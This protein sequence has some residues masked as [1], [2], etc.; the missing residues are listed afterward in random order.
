[1][2]FYSAAFLVAT[3]GFAAHAYT[4]PTVTPVAPHSFQHQHGTPTSSST[5]AGGHVSDFQTS[6]LDKDPDNARQTME[7]FIS[8]FMPAAAAGEFEITSTY[9]TAHNGI[10]HV[11]T[12]QVIDGVPVMNGVG[13]LNLDRDGNVISS[14]DSFWTGTVPAHG[15]P[16]LDKA[17]AARKFIKA[18]SEDGDVA[19]VT[20]HPAG[21]ARQMWV[22]NGNQLQLAWVFEVEV[23]NLEHVVEVAI[24]ATNGDVLSAHDLVIGDEEDFADSSD[25]EGPQRKLAQAGSAAKYRGWGVPN[26][27]PEFGDSKLHE[28]PQNKVPEASPLGWHQTDAAQPAYRDTRGNNVFA[29]ENSADSSSIPP[30]GYRPESQSASALEFDFPMD[31]TRD[32]AA[33]ENLDATVTNL[34]LM[35]NIMHDLLYTYGFDEE[36]GNFQSNNFG[37]GGRGNDPLVANALDGSGKNNANMYTP[38]D[39]SSPV[40]RMYRW[41]DLPGE[42]RPSSLDGLVVAHE[43]VHGLSNRLTGGPTNSGCLYTLESGGMGEGWSDYVGVMMSIGE[44]SGFDGSVGVGSWLVGGR[45]I[46]RYEYS[47]DFSVNPFTFSDVNDASGVHEIGTIWATMLWDM[48]ADLVTQVG[49]SDDIYQSSDGASAQGGNNIAMQN[50]I[51]GMKLQPC[52]PNFVDARDAI[53]MADSANYGGAHKC[54]IWKAF[55]RRGLGAFAAHT[56]GAEES[57]CVPDECNLEG[58][59]C[60]ETSAPTPAPYLDQDL[61]ELV[62]PAPGTP[63]VVFLEGSTQGRTNTYG[64]PAGDV[65][66]SFSLPAGIDSGAL[67]IDTCSEKTNYDSYFWLLDSGGNLVAENDDS[68]GLGVPCNAETSSYLYLAADELQAGEEYQLVIDGYDTASGT[69]GL[70]VSLTGSGP[71]GPVPTPTPPPQTPTPST[72]PPTASPPT[73][74]PSTAPPTAGPSTGSPTAVPTVSP[75]TMDYSVCDALYLIQ[76]ELGNGALCASILH[77]NVEYDCG[78]VNPT[79]DP[80]LTPTSAPTFVPTPAPTSAPTLAPTADDAEVSVQFKGAWNQRFTSERP[81]YIT[82]LGQGTAETAPANMGLVV[83]RE[84]QNVELSVQAPS[85]LGLLRAVRICLDP[86]EPD[87]TRLSRSSFELVFNGEA[88]NLVLSSGN[89]R[90]LRPG[91]CLEESLILA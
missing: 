14:S 21:S 38:S 19:P 13:Q 85:D 1:M 53:L 63:S 81:I 89:M 43:Y 64:N 50:V 35:N 41:N 18:M 44:E 91:Q 11:H 47:T 7:A 66:I 26:V 70:T 3:T 88:Y 29:Q 75:T 76:D 39:G 62:A 52:N 31:F 4:I 2:R 65:R 30:A 69:F 17:A 78:L 60:V 51:D 45:G 40:M 8:P 73:L 72:S 80:T 86:L 33:G 48:S 77:L 54:I 90:A 32:P 23:G 15:K 74:G 49:F 87:R 34:F 59:P 10:V 20:N 46:R 42:E 37:K 56:R 58:S 28:N 12:H 79:A 57:F 22:V 83:A 16:N 67:Q 25:T 9:T 36:S 27:T 71:T 84:V 68:R 82:F 6:R 5:A 55:A 24:D 61:G